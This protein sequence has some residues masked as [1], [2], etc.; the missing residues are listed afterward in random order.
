MNLQKRVLVLI[1]AL[2]ALSLSVFAAPGVIGDAP[3]IGNWNDTMSA[4]MTEGTGAEVGLW[5]VDVSIG[6][7]VDAQWKVLADESL[8]FGGGDIG[9]KNGQNMSGFGGPATTTT[10]TYYFD[11]RD[12]SGDG[13][14][15][16][17]DTLGS[18]LYTMDLAPWTIAGS[19]QNEAGAPGDWLPNDL[20]MQLHDD[21]LNGDAVAADGILSFQFKPLGDLTEGNTAFKVVSVRDAG[22]DWNGESKLSVD[23]FA[24][25][26][27][28]ND[29]SNAPVTGGF[30]TADLVTIEADFHTGRIRT[31]VDEGAGVSDWQDM[32]W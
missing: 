31:T 1:A 10:I 24:T 6:A 20:T 2:S 19:I 12:R 7:G 15:P 3:G 4:V 5:S 26:G 21:G 27:I 18:N 22:T 23:G 29:N 16:T 30:T 9:G 32:K 13:W 14:S 8:G 11:T 17:T 28:G 25:D